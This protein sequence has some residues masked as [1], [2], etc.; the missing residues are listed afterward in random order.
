MIISFWGPTKVI[1]VKASKRNPNAS[2]IVLYC[3]NHVTGCH[4]FY[5]L[6]RPIKI[7]EEHAK[8]IHS[9]R[10]RNYTRHETCILYTC[11]ADFDQKHR[12][13]QPAMIHSF[14]K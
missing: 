7:I 8:T 12:L 4:I 2:G 13:I 10:K 9:L 11:Q 5:V 3:S 1:S 6:L 14:S